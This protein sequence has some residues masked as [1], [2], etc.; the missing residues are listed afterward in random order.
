VKAMPASDF[1][2]LIKEVILKEYEAYA[3]A[4]ILQLLTDL[5]VKNMRCR[6]EILVGEVSE[7]EESHF[8]QWV[9]IDVN[10][11]T[12]DV[13]GT[14]LYNLDEYYKDKN[15]TYLNDSKLTSIELDKLTE[16]TNVTAKSYFGG[17]DSVLPKLLH[18]IGACIGMKD[19]T[20]NA[21]QKWYP[22]FSRNPPTEHQC[23]IMNP[24]HQSSKY[25]RLIVRRFKLKD[26]DIF[27][28]PRGYFSRLFTAVAF[29]FNERFES[30]EVFEGA[31]DLRFSERFGE[32]VQVVIRFTGEYFYLI[33]VSV[34]ESA[35]ITS[36]AWQYYLKIVSLFN[37]TSNMLL[38]A[39]SNPFHW[40]QDNIVVDE[41]C[42]NPKKFR[43]EGIDFD[44]KNRAS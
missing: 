5:V 38:K 43:F 17:D 32:K 25:S 24:F 20:A 26:A 30:V 10:W 13:L 4:V 28:F 29:L 22:N 21:E 23:K 12:R 18:C 11:L 40:H 14:I 16:K 7:E 6:G 37:R 39:D 36:T 42:C 8:T 15:S 27:I 2:H 41:F 35:P 19:R 9:V 3:D 44:R 31:M 1:H 33:V 34:K